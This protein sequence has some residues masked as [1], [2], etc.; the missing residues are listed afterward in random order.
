MRLI[1]STLFGLF[2]AAALSTTAQGK[3]MRSI[4]IG[5]VWKD[6]DGNE[7][8]ID[9][10]QNPQ[11]PYDFSVTLKDEPDNLVLN[12]IAVHY[13]SN[14]SVPTNKAAGAYTKLK[15]VIHVPF[16]KTSP[17]RYEAV[18]YEDAILNQRYPH[19]D[20]ECK[21]HLSL[22]LAQFQP[23]PNLSNVVYEATIDPENIKEKV[24][25]GYWRYVGYI[26]RYRYNDPTIGFKEL[27]MVMRLGPTSK[28]NFGSVAQRQLV[29]M[30]TELK[31][32]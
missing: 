13:E 4:P 16:K 14:C 24:S 3:P 10:N 28:E 12:S 21:W 27:G 30:I 2:L 25:D 11:Q 23:Q 26:T 20:K 18:V 29:T 22:V 5:D 32:K 9:F 8:S 31:R 17:H 6:A 1:P 19:M 7:Y 15:K